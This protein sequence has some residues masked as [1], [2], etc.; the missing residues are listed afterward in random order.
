[1]ALVGF[2]GGAL[3]DAW[4]ATRAG[5]IA[6]SPRVGEQRSEADAVA[7][8][9]AGDV[10][11][12]TGSRDDAPRAVAPRTVVGMDAAVAELSARRLA[13]PVDE[14]DVEGWKGM[15]AESRGNRAHEAVD[16]VRPRGTPVRAVE[17]GRVEKLLESRAGGLTIYQSDPAN[18]HIYYY[19]HLDGYAQG[20]GEGDRV[21]R[22]EVIGF[23]GTTGNAPRDV[24][25]L[26]F[27]IFVLDERGRWWEGT[28][29]DPYLVYRGR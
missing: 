19:A 27:A 4:L 16:I 29:I 22:G 18:R 8:R 13:L 14:A 28:P 10:M 24:P 12:T 11:G 25:H 6:L 21:R 9:A 5:D 23:A 26:H 17:D 1:V 3:V 2:C 7:H 15:F 20:L